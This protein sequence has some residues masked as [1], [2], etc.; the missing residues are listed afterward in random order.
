MATHSQGSN[1]TLQPSGQLHW[2]HWSVVVLSLVL[3]FAAWYITSEQA[4][5]RARSR[6]DFQ[7]NRTLALVQERMAKYEEALW[8]GVAALQ[9][10]PQETPRAH[11]RTFADS[12]DI[13]YRYPGINGIGVIHYVPP[14]KLTDYLAWQRQS[15]ADYA[16]HPEHDKNEYWPI[17][18]IEPQQNNRQAVGL[19]MAHEQNRHSAAL[20]ARNTG[21]ATITGP[22]ILVQDAQQTPGFLFYAP[23]FSQGTVP[24]THGDEHSGFLGLVYAPFIMFRLMDGTLANANRQ[25]NFSIHDGEHELYNELNTDSENYDPNPLYTEASVVPMYGRQWRFNAAV[26]PAVP[27]P[28]NL[29]PAADDSDRWPD[30]RRAA[31]DHLPAA[32]QSQPQRGQLRPAGDPA[33]GKASA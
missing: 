16:I 7:V 13:D 9:T 14:A 29:Q 32:G 12:L 27:R 5:E 3:T 6:F 21:E 15:L 10:L 19:D 8:A 33:P 22:I 25:V 30:H 11:W 4:E 18:Y 20:R 28:A 31:A 2:Y 24:A 26:H 1:E 23:W 17:T